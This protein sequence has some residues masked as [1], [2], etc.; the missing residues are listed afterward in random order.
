MRCPCVIKRVEG[1]GVFIEKLK[2]PVFQ[3]NLLRV[4]VP[5][6]EPGVTGTQ[7]QHVSRYTTP[8]RYSKNS[9]QAGNRKAPNAKFFLYTRDILVIVQYYGRI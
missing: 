6:F 2:N 4:G 1:L 3:L 5:G 9:I 7:N 8:R